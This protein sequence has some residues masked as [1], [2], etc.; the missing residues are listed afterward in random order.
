MVIISV[1]AVGRAGGWVLASREGGGRDD[2]QELRHEKEK[3]KI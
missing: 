3:K 2:C 1:I